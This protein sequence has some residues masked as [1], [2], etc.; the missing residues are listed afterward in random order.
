MQ[1]Q[2]ISA[3]STEKLSSKQRNSTGYTKAVREKQYFT[4]R[5]WGEVALST[6]HGTPCQGLQSLAQ[7]NI[8]QT[9][10]VHLEAGTGLGLK[11][12]PLHSAMQGLH[13]AALPSA[14]GK[15]SF[16]DLTDDVSD[17]DLEVSLQSGTA[18]VITA[19]S[20]LQTMLL[21]VVFCF[22]HWLLHADAAG[23]GGQSIGEFLP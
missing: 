7:Q 19:A 3:V 9:C 17:T 20:P 4:Q 6:G 22:R 18:A 12:A 11:W 21:S 13:D 5:S 1:S 16:V 15:S 23:N 14:V 8:L 10:Q 2:R